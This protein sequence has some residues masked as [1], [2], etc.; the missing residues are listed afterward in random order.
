MERDKLK[1]GLTFVLVLFLGIAGAV[2]LYFYENF[3]SNDLF[4]PG[5]EIGGISVQG[6]DRNAAAKAVEMGVKEIYATPVI[7]FKD[8]YQQENKLGELCF[9][10]NATEIVDSA[11]RDEKARSWLAKITNLDG[12]R[13]INYPVSIPYN[14]APQE[15]LVQQWDN[16]WGT[17]YSNASLEVDSRRGLIIIPAQAGFRVDGESTFKVLP[18]ELKFS[19]KINVPIIMMQQEPAVKEEMLR[20]MGELSNYST[21]FNTAEVNRSHNL[22]M[23]TS[24]I[25]KSIINPQTAFSFNQTVGIRTMESGYMDALVIV[26]NKFEPG[27]GGGICQVSSTLYNACLLAGLEIVERHNHNLAVA[28]VPLGRDATVAYGIQ[29][30]RFKNNTDSPLYIRAVTNGGRLTINIYG[31]LKYKQK[32]AITNII[33]GTI[34]YVKVKE[35]DER[36][37]PGEEKVDHKGQPGYVV[38]SFRTFYDNDGKTIKTQQLARDTYRPLNEIIFAGPPLEPSTPIEPPD[39]DVDVPAEGEHQAGEEPIGPLDPDAPAEPEKEPEIQSDKEPKNELEDEP[40]NDSDP[41]AK[42][43]SEPK[44]EEEP[45]QLDGS[46]N[47]P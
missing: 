19:A 42:N 15:L 25:N 45:D 9:P 18:T 27:M 2:A 29:D 32:I 26:G 8:D 39:S 5:V 47:L 23:A 36:L 44:D 34:D 41:E 24:S 16:K 33:D 17:P 31:N 12:K 43:E 20:D 35:L 37:Q 7:F 1:S 10:I 3:L 13:K 21:Y 28:Y 30:F 11:W 6:Y 4:M 46:N 40:K 14:T 22:Y 38:R